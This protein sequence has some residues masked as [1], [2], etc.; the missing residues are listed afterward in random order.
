MTYRGSP[1]SGPPFNG[2]APPMTP[3][4]FPQMYGNPQQRYGQSVPFVAPPPVPAAT[5]Q[6][7]VRAPPP[8]VHQY[9]QFPTYHGGAFARPS[10]VPHPTQLP[11][12][13]YV[14]HQ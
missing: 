4:N 11:P 1:P 7:L 14:H 6:P 8:P 3:A 12:Q 2:Q 13:Q 5:S 9:S 10:P